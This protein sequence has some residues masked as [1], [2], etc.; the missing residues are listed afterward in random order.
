MVEA[1]PST[2]LLSLLQVLFSLGHTGCLGEL[3]LSDLGGKVVLG[4]GCSAG[5]LEQRVLQLRSQYD[6]APVS[7]PATNLSCRG[8]L[9]MVG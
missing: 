6:T 3:V 2:L 4:S 8:R 5:A 1:V 7:Q 9:S